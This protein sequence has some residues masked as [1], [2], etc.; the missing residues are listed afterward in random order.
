MN[1]STVVEEDHI[2][3]LSKLIGTL[4]MRYHIKTGTG[5]HIHRAP[6]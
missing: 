3:F 1:Q 5:R 6:L 4:I 2:L